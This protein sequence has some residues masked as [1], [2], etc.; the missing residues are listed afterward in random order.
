MFYGWWIAIAG[1]VSQAYTAGA[2]WQG[3]GAFFDPI[4]E[5]FGWSRATTAAAVSIQRTETGMVA[6]FVGWFVNRFGPRRVMLVGVLI[7]GLGFIL[8]GQIQELW[9][10]YAVFVLITIGLSFGTF[11]V[12]TTTVANWFVA[13]RGRALALTF[14]GSGLGGLLVPLVVWIIS[15]TD[16]RSGLVIIGLGFWGMGIPV[17]LIMR[18]RPEDYGYLPDGAEAP[19][20]DASASG[21]DAADRTEGPG[22]GSRET[23]AAFTTGQ[24][25]TTRAFWQLA[26]AMGAGQLII[27]ASIHHFPAMTSFG[28]SREVAGLAIM[29]VSLFSLVGRV[30]SGVLGD[31]MDKRRVMALAFTLQFIGTLIFANATN[32]WHLW[33]FMAFWGLGF[34]GSIPVRFALLADYF[35]RRSFGSILGTM[36]TVSTIFGV[37]GPIFVGW[38]ADQQDNYRDAFMIVSGTIL[39]AIPVIL[40]VTQPARRVA[41]PR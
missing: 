25:L 36:V 22:P 37:I 5:Q 7:T 40:T 31:R 26:I 24:A 23:E 9:Q 17:A 6:P 30:M 21:T 10:F 1:S 32:M 29:G 20:R 28:I 38:L 41:T 18:S 34:G 3:F 4:V 12:V 11:L 27:S 14:A 33:G 15:Q 8:L 16:W 35:G 39:L 13:K 19:L 2:F